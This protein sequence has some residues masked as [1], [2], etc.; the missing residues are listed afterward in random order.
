MR[1]VC[2]IELQNKKEWIIPSVNR[3]SRIKEINYAE[4]WEM[5][6][7]QTVKEFVD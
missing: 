1:W 5:N 4:W 6:L 2:Q 7:I 3:T